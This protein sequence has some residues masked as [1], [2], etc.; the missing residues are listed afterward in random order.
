METRTE[1]PPPQQQ[2]RPLVSDAL[3][4]PPVTERVEVE[5]KRRRPPVAIL[6][7]SAILVI[8]GLIWGLR[9][10]VYANAHQTTDDA[11]V[12][13]DT[14]TVTSKIQERVRDVLVDTNQPVRKGQIIIRLD[15][16]DEL[17]ALQQ[18]RAGLGAQ[19]AQ[20]RAAQENV[21]LTR[22]QVQAQATQGAGGIV[23]AQSG[24][25]NA[26][27]QTQSAQQQADASRSAIAQAQY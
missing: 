25:R 18:A 20:A 6:F 14:V 12:D 26:Q 21:A 3:G 5:T 1:P 22:A 27:A 8:A 24:V 17:A 23:A 16:T 13:A 11:R 10:L 19:R 4:A 7:V 2:P 15:D 9:Y